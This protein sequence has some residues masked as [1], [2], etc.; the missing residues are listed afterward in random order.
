MSARPAPPGL[1]PARRV[2]RSTSGWDGIEIVPDSEEERIKNIIELSSDE[3][4]VSKPR[5]LGDPAL[6]VPGAWPEGSPLR[7]LPGRILHTP[8]TPTSSKKRSGVQ[9][10]GTPTSSR[11][12]PSKR[13]QAVQST[14]ADATENQ[15]V[16]IPDLHHTPKSKVATKHFYDKT[17]PSRTPNKSTAGTRPFL[18]GA[19][20]SDSSDIEILDGPTPGPGPTRPKLKGKLQPLYDDDDSDDDGQTETTDSSDAPSTLSLNHIPNKYA[21][22]WTPTPPTGTA[23]GRKAS[24][25]KSPKK[26]SQAALARREAAEKAAHQAEYAAQVYSYLNKVAFN[27]QLPSLRELEIKWNSRLKTTAGRA[28]FHRDKF[29]KE[30]AEIELAPKVVDCDE[31]IRNTLAHEMC[32][33]ATWYIDKDINAYHGK[34]FNKWAR[35]VEKKDSNLTISIQH[36][37]EIY[38][39]FE[40][41]CANCSETVGRHHNSLD[42]TKTKCPACKTGKLVAQFEVKRTT[43]KLAAV[44]PQGSPRPGA[45]PASPVVIF[46]ESSDEEEDPVTL[47]SLHAQKEIYVVHD[48]DS[49]SGRKDQTIEDLA[50][51]FEGITIAHKVCLHAKAKRRARH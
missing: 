16:V 45:R 5:R 24:P 48:S 10:P 15:V 26:L 20:E 35:R 37:Y 4:E 28:R 23:S 19:E 13:P 51:Q 31:R 36:T 12:Q 39:P 2:A 3:E 7:N 27:D 49:E 8:E 6:Q 30:F 14:S 40:W 43:S 50:R 21:R 17:G 44:K 9:T 11:K 25:S 47:P 29:G 38:Y 18:K 32:H 46:I 22:Y 1:G 41:M 33:L 34:L 42:P